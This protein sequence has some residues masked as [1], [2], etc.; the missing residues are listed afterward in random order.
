ME[1]LVY[2]CSHRHGGVCALSM[3]LQPASSSLHPAGEPSCTTDTWLW[4]LVSHSLSSGQGLHHS[5]LGMWV[6][7]GILGNCATFPD[8]GWLI[9]LLREIKGSQS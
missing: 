7:T 8:L 1:V 6:Q 4:V 3:A 9:A 2:R 5:L